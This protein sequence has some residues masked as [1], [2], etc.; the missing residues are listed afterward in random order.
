MWL[1]NYEQC[2]FASSF[3]SENQ[4]NP[5]LSV[6]ATYLWF[7]LPGLTNASLLVVPNYDC[8]PQTPV[9]FYYYYFYYSEGP[10]GGPSGT[11][12]N[13]QSN[14][15]RTAPMV[16]RDRVSDMIWRGSNLVCVL[17]GE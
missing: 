2:A 7:L 17:L 1:P 15:P 16:Q 14:K 6:F 9:S 12:Q 11:A 10:Q 3:C 13:R 8:H 5:K 4:N